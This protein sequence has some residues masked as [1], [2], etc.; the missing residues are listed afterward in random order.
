MKG[1]EIRRRH[2]GCPSIDKESGIHQITRE[3]RMVPV[4]EIEWREISL[5]T[6][7]DII[8]E[9]GSQKERRPS[10][11]STFTGLDHRFS[12]DEMC[13]DRVDSKPE[14]RGIVQRLGGGL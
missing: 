4:E 9:H 11:N 14:E 5:S 10:G 8:S 2:V 7:S 3:D 13:Q 12:N 1:E 6:N